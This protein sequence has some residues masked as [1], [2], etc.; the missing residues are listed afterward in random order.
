M[1][2]LLNG[3]PPSRFNVSILPKSPHQCAKSDRLLGRRGERARRIEAEADALV[4][5][6]GPQAYS[7]ARLR[8]HEASSFPMTQEWNRIACAVARKTHNRV[9]LDTATPMAADFHFGPGRMTNKAEAPPFFDARAQLEEL[10]RVL[11]AR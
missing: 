3:A 4:R 2:K 6:Y 8:E 10:E 1:R 9:G 11:R 7:V 5:D